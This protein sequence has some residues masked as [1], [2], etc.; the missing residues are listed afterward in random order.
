MRSNSLFTIVIFYFVFD[1]DKYYWEVLQRASF[2]QAE[3]TVKK[4]GQKK[5]F[6]LIVIEM[7]SQLNAEVSPNIK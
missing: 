6:E 5:L 2:K 1:R 3:H 4:F 7:Y